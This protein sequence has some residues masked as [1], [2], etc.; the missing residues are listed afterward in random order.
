MQI[1]YQGAKLL[2]FALQMTDFGLVMI[3]RSHPKVFL[4]NTVVIGK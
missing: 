4:F 3:D 2:D 1:K